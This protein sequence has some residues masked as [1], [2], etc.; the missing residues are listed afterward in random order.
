MYCSTARDNRA[1]STTTAGTM[2]LISREA[3][4]P[5]PPESQRDMPPF[6]PDQYTTADNI[7]IDSRRTRR[8]HDEKRKNRPEPVPS[9]QYSVLGTQEQKSRVAGE[10]S[11]ASRAAQKADALGS[12]LISFTISLSSASRFDTL[13]TM[14]KPTLKTGCHGRYAR[15]NAL[16]LRA[17]E[18]KN[19]PPRTTRR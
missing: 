8:R 16:R 19:E 12:S 9:S 3:G 17:G 4:G 7:S 10:P 18:S 6:P 2:Q 13:H 1:P 15:R 5:P 11:V 14:R